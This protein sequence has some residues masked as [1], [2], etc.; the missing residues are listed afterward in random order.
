[1]D[2][3]GNLRLREASGHERVVEHQ[4]VQRLRELA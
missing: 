2:L 4:L 1:L 3:L